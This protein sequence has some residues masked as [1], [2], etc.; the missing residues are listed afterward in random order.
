MLLKK[1]KS[2]QL[3]IEYKKRKSQ[4]VIKNNFTKKSVKVGIRNI[5]KKIL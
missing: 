1:F 2:I 5:L 3:S 4:F